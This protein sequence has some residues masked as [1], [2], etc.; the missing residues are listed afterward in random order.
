ME[1]C[2][3]EGT[4]GGCHFIALLNAGPISKSDQVSQGRLQ[5]SLESLVIFQVQV[6]VCEDVVKKDVT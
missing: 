5:S 6:T 1:R 2:R 4:S 3:L